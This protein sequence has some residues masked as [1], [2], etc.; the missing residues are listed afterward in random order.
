MRTAQYLTS[1]CMCYQLWSILYSSAEPQH[2]DASLR[3]SDVLTRRETCRAARRVS[4]RPIS[5]TGGEN[6][7]VL[8]P[9]NL[10]S[11]ETS[12]KGCGWFAL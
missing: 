7:A 2:D 10:P 9:S 5:V 12:G 4:G 6:E 3:G 1:T 8:D 11:I